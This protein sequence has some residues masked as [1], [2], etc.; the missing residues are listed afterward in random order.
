MLKLVLHYVTSDRESLELSSC[1]GC[2]IV[3]Q[4]YSYNGSYFLLHNANLM[5]YSCS[6]HT[7]IYSMNIDS[8]LWTEQIIGKDSFS[9][10]GIDKT[11]KLP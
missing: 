11:F 8:R 4:C 2:I 6:K 5:D 9:D 1:R 7:H 10:C 3:Y